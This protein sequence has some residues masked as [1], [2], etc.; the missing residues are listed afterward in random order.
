MTARK[1]N[2]RPH[3]A[4]SARLEVIPPPEVPSCQ[5]LINH[6]RNHRVNVSFPALP[7]R[8][9]GTARAGLSNPGQGASPCG[10]AHRS[11]GDAAA[12][13]LSV[14]ACGGASCSNQLNR[15]LARRQRLSRNN[16]ADLEQ[17][18]AAPNS[19]LHSW[20]CTPTSRRLCSRSCS[21]FPNAT[22]SNSSAASARS[23]HAPCMC[24]MRNCSIEFSN[25]QSLSNRDLSTGRG[26]GGRRA[27]GQPIWKSNRASGRREAHPGGSRKIR[28]LIVGSG[29]SPIS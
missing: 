25:T 19:A 16:R 23:P 8:R 21:A 14:N 28:F 4:T 27:A 15:V 22:R 29:G 10:R 24:S 6:Y 1:P 17:M 12:R 7:P 5:C 9:G 20:P 2:N 3:D 11:G 13:A 18:C 26:H